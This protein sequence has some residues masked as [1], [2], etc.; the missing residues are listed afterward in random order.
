MVLFM[1]AGLLAMAL[2]E[3]HGWVARGAGGG[4]PDRRVFERR[5]KA[6]AGVAVAGD[7]LRGL[8]V[9]AAF[10]GVVEVEGAGVGGQE[11]GAG[12]EEGA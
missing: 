7:R 5:R 12:E 11:R 4:G 6:L 2:V 8:R 10:A 3:V 1:G 9:T